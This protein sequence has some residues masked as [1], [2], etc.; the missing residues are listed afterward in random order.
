M[1]NERERIILTGDKVECSSESLV[2]VSRVFE[3]VEGSDEGHDHHQQAQET[4][5]YR[6]TRVVCNYYTNALNECSKEV[7]CVDKLPIMCSSSEGFLRTS[8]LFGNSVWYLQ[9]A[10]GLNNRII[11]S[12]LSCQV[13]V[14]NYSQ[15]LVGCYCCCRRGRFGRISRVRCG[16]RRTPSRLTMT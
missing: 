14:C 3:G 15:V 10:E 2:D 11:T 13:N 1:A 5:D 16:S 4:K 8:D 7:S 6:R 9:W 12:F